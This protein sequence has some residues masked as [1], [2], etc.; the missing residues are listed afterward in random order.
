MTTE[1]WDMLLAARGSAMRDAGGAVLEAVLFGFLTLL[2]INEGNRTLAS[3]H[4]TRLVETH[5][6]VRTVF[7]QSSGGDEQS[8]RMRT[9]AAAVLVATTEVIE[10]YQRL[11]MGS[12]IDF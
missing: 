3:D 12:M 2:N 5:D 6:W 7:E 9:M 1:L 11:L 10:K 4:A 8:D